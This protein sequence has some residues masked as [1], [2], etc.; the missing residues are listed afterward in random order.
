MSRR[1]RDDRRRISDEEDSRGSRGEKRK[2]EA[3]DRDRN[4]SRKERKYDDKEQDRSYRKNYKRGKSNSSSDSDSGSESEEEVEAPN[5]GLSGL[6]TKDTNQVNG[7][8]LKYS[9]P[10]EARKPSKKWLFIPFK[11]DEA[12]PKISVSKK[13]AYLF[14]R[15]R[16]ISDIP[17][18]HPSC[19]SQHAVLQ[20]RSVPEID[21]VGC[22]TGRNVVK[23]YL[24]DLESTNGTL[25]N[26]KKIDPARYYELRLKDMLQFGFST[27]EYVFLYE[28]VVKADGEE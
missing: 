16:N 24:M 25:L 21:D 20:F 2:F 3:K 15:D 1:D 4:D 18:D 22:K 14:G 7:V 19:S 13:S 11:G 8:E 5:F 26:G 9:E 6:L 17:T 28:E 27:R 12:L 10:Q 23:P